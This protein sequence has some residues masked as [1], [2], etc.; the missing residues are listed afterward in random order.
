MQTHGQHEYFISLSQF[1]A[2]YQQYCTLQGHTLDVNIEERLKAFGVKFKTID[3]ARCIGL[4]WKLQGSCK[5]Q[6]DTIV[7]VI[8]CGAKALQ[9]SPE[10][11]QWTNC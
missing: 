9:E 3:S 8:H 11:N 5:T 6:L 4:R 2:D 10:Y 7:W 1:T